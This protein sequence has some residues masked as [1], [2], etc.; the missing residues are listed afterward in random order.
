VGRVPPQDII[1]NPLIPVQKALSCRLPR[2]IFID[3]DVY[4]ISE[5]AVKARYDA[6][7]PWVTDGDE[8]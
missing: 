5:P 4:P 1:L 8:V 2:F 6:R 7:H 3:S